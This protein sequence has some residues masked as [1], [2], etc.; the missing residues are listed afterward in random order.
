MSRPN[1]RSILA[2]WQ[3]EP[4]TD[5]AEMRRMAAAAW[6]RSDWL[7]VRLADVRSPLLRDALR[8]IGTTLYGEREG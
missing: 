1:V 7:C 3:P 8:A 2:R 4:A 5:E 6:H